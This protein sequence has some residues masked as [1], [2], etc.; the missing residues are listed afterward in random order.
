MS[1]ALWSDLLAHGLI[2]ELYLMIGSRMVAGD[3][4]AFANVPKADLELLAVRSCKG[5]NNALLQPATTR[6]VTASWPA[7]TSGISR[8]ETSEQSSCFAAGRWLAFRRAGMGSLQVSRMI[9]PL[10][11]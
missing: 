9:G 4:P 8:A 1:R 6:L 7:R 11:P 5:S 3:S 2:H 10:L